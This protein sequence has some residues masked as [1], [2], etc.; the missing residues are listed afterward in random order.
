VAGHEKEALSLQNE[1]ELPLGPGAVV[2]TEAYRQEWVRAGGREPGV[3]FGS[4]KV[5]GAE[6]CG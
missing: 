2:D 6:K 5:D 1:G 3:R 4:W